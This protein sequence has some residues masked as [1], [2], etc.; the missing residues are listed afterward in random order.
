MTN[1][2][3]TIQAMLDE[4]ERATA[5]AW[6]VNCPVGHEYDELVFYDHGEAQ[7]QA[8]MFNDDCPEDAPEHFVTPLYERANVPALC[9]ALLAAV[10][11]LENDHNPRKA[12]AAITKHLE[13][14]DGT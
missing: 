11:A 3:P 6:V 12:L 5:K 7:T 13:A 1:P 10:E 2:T 9:R 4:A 14:R 8:E